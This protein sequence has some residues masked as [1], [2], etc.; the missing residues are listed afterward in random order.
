M[1]V[2]FKD[3]LDNYLEIIE[4]EMTHIESYQKVPLFYEPIHYMLELK[5]KRIRPLLTLLSAMIFNI[6]A[7]EAKYA[8]AAVELLHNF[9]LVHDDIMDKDATRRGNPTIHTKWD[10]G[11]AILAGDGL[12]G[13]AFRK[14]LQ[15]PKGDIPAM[16]RRL[17]ETMMVICEGQGLDKMFEEMENVTL[18]AY[19]D[20]IACKTAVLIELACELGGLAAGADKDSI[21][22]LKEYGY[23]LGMGFQIQDDYL[24]ITADETMLGKKIGSDLQMR[25][26]TILTILLRELTGSNDFFGLDLPDFKKLLNDYSMPDRV[27]TMCTEYFSTAYDKLAMLPSNA[28]AIQLKELTDLLK[29]RSW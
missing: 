16:M 28:F 26:K 20:M 17:T 6:K 7:D 1:T 5:G 23:A 19:L 21:Q 11:T 10:L 8:A 24:D 4:N 18:D 9:T 15:S 12:M 27:N 22:I 14:L 2:R 13:L 3:V 29:N 25:K